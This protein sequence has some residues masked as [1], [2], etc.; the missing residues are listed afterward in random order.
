MTRSEFRTIVA[1]PP[2]PFIWNGNPGGRRRSKTD[3]GYTCMSL[4]EIEQFDLP[5]CH[6]DATLFLWVTPEHFRSGAGCQVARAWGFAPATEIVWRKRNFGMGR[7]PRIGHEFLLIAHRGRGSIR[8]EAPRNLHS[9]QDWKQSYDV[10]GGKGHSRKPPAAMDL[11]EV[12]TEGP[13]IELFARTPRLG[14]AH[15]GH[16]F[17]GG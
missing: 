13:R 8:S 11:I 16:G 14:W 12:V 5:L 9:V 4:P 15:E 17:C 6:T 7:W 3:L 2:W 1:D 10:R